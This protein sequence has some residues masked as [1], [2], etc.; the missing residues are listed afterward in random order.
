[1]TD[2]HL[3]NTIHM[4]RRM[5]TAARKEGLDVLLTDDAYKSLN[6][7]RRRRGLCGIHTGD[8]IYAVGTDDPSLMSKAC[9][10]KQL[11]E[12][13]RVPTKRSGVMV[14]RLLGLD[15]TR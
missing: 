13:K 9:Y 5:V 7:E 11:E 3:L 2:S 15:G 10:T 12:R 4:I 14:A 8:C 1:M 6:R